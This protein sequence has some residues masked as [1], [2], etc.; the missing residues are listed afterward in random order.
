MAY[1]LHPSSS[2]NCCSSIE[3]YFMTKKSMGSCIYLES[4]F[5]RGFSQYMASGGEIAYQQLCG[6]I[7]GEFNDCSKQVHNIYLNNFFAFSFIF[8][9]ML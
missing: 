6:E 5:G 4:I 1:S 3:Y 8:N 2:L 9:G 7:T